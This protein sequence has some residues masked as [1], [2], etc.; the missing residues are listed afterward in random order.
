M[1]QAIRLISSSGCFS[2]LPLRSPTDSDSACRFQ[3]RSWR[4]TG[5]ASGCT[6]ERRGLRNF[7]FVFRFR[8]DEGAVSGPI[9][10]V[11]DDE[12]AVRDALAEMLTVFGF[13]VE[14]HDSAD[15]LLAAL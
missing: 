15:S 4:R 8:P 12:A 1:V 5:G 7:V 10:F 11:V 14:T 9:V 13:N 3:P 6:R 2:R